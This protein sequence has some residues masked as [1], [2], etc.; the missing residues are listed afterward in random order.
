MSA[1]GRAD[2]V[3][4]V[5]FPDTSRSLIKQAIEEGRVHREDVHLLNPRLSGGREV[6]LLTLQDLRFPNLNLLSVNLTSF[7]KMTRWL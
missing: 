5:A 3:L 1:E 4:A 6:L 7:M 2:K